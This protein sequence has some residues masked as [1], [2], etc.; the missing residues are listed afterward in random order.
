MAEGSGEDS[1]DSEESMKSYYIGLAMIVLTLLIFSSCML[2]LTPGT[3][4]VIGCIKYCWLKEGTGST[5]PAV[6]LKTITQG[7][8]KS[9]APNYWPGWYPITLDQEDE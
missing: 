3:N 9:T 8:I 4:L 7:C 5:E 2:S 1:E 6:E